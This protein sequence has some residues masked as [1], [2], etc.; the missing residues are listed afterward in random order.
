MKRFL[1]WLIVIG[2]LLLI[3][4]VVRHLRTGGAAT[5][6]TANVTRGPITQAVTDTGTLI[7]Y[8]PVYEFDLTVTVPGQQP[9][10]VTHQ[11]MVAH[12][13]IGNFQPGVTTPVRVDPADQ[14]KLI[15]G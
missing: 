5:Y 10:E 14:T 13:V 8:N 9:Y 15:F 12:A 1:P 4:F 2:G 3:A 6:Q 11:Q 7:N